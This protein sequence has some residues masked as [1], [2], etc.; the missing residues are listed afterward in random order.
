MNIYYCK[1]L[2]WYQQLKVINHFSSLFQVSLSWRSPID[3]GGAP[4]TGYV[5][6]RR[7]TKRDAWLDVA[8]IE[9]VSKTMTTVSQVIEGESYHFQVMAVNKE[10]RGDPVQ[11]Q[12]VTVANPYRYTFTFFEELSVWTVGLKIKFPHDRRALWLF[13]KRIPE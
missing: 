7:D 12:M 11:S 2:F 3:E 9:D 6:Q 4:V 5:I 1:Y 8:A 10:G 13:N